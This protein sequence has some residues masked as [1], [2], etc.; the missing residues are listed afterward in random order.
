MLN[1]IAGATDYIY[2]E[3]QFFQTDFGEP[4][5]DVFSKAGIEQRSG[6]VQFLMSDFANDMKA[7]LSSAK[8]QGKNLLPANEIGNA[9]GKRIADAI[10]WDQPFHVYLVLPVHPEGMLND[11]A[12]VGQI[13]W[14]MQSLVYAENSLLNQVRQA[15]AAR[16][17]C[18]NPLDKSAWDEA[19]RS[20]KQK[21]ST[22]RA[23]P[24]DGVNVN[25]CKKYVTL[26]NLRNC[27]SVDGLVRTEQIYVH[28][29]L[30]IVD[31]RQM[32]IGSANINDR[33]QSGKRDSE[34]AVMLIDSQK[35]PGK[36]RGMTH[37]NPLA[38]KYRVDLWKKH[39]AISSGGNEFVKPATDMLALLE[40]PASDRTIRAIQDMA[41]ANAA[42][43]SKSFA[44]VPSGGDPEHGTSLWPVCP[45]NT[46][47]GKAAG[48]AKKMPFDKQFWI[49]R[50]KV[51]PLTKI[52]GYFTALPIYWTVGENNHPGEMSVM[53]LTDSG[54]REEIGYANA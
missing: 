50:K 31:D 27:E 35:T 11:I 5:I 13:H 22:L 36:L 42:V 32:I 34:L 33:S 6:P 9:L 4:S 30:L 2:I 47:M 26:L 53:L 16:A 25:Q 12:I 54:Q 52:I 17:L 3:N 48:Y 39:F 28:S 21:D 51:P 8:A 15:I 19:M 37:V 49:E 10:R 29:K 41:S 18:K 20:A 40:E 24:A 38:R 43:Y 7:K 44:H 23:S 1:L 14:T 45:L 46:P